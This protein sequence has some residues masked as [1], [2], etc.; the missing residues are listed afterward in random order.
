MGWFSPMRCRSGRIATAC[1]ADSCSD[2][3]GSGSMEGPAERY[4]SQWEADVV[5]RDGTPMHIRPIRPDDAEALQRMHLAQSEQSR[6]L[7]FFAPVGRLSDRDLHRFTHVDHVERVAL[8]LTLGGEIRA[9]GR[10]DVVGA[11]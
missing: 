4:P 5:L 10:F 1:T 2:C 11:G 9:V 3:L 7:R 6:Y 8:V